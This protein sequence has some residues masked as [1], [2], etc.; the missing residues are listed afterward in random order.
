M[1]QPAK[2]AT[3]AVAVTGLVVQA[4]VPPTLVL[5]MARVIGAEAVVTTALPEFSIL[6]TGWALNTTPL[7]VVPG[8]VVKTSFKVP[9]IVKVFEVSPVSPVL[10]ALRLKF[11]PAVPVISHPAK[12]AVPLVAVTGLVV[13]FSVPVPEAMDKETEAD[14]DVTTLP[15]A[16]STWTTGW[17]LNVTPLFVVPGDVVKFS[18]VAEPAVMVKLVEV[19]EVRPVLVAESLK[20]PAV[21]VMAQPAKVAAPAVAVT[22]LVVQESVPEPLATDKVIGAEAVVTTAL[23]EFSI[24][25]TGWVLNATP[26]A[27]VPGVAVKASF[28]VP[29]I[30]KV[31]EVTEVR[32]VL[33]AIRL[34][35]VPA[36]PVISH[37]AKVAIPD[38]AVTGLVV[39]FSVPV[40]EAMARET[41]ADEDVTVAPLAFSTFTTGWALN[42]TPL[43]VVPGVALNASLVAPPPPAAR[44]RVW[45]AVAA[46]VP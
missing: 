35:F 6:T 34:K 31:L 8:V 3:P 26:L 16:S 1:A 28:K 43:F 41:E 21:P 45:V 29:L 12:V 25:T 39:Q 32:P 44:T 36:V 2:V 17:A 22:G 37:P 9:L 7:L 33:V 5:P 14:E 15:L 4:S 42:V 30:V 10:V 38:T 11:V 13:Q 18:W 46:P 19:T 24:L 27:V 23:P 20:A 40:P